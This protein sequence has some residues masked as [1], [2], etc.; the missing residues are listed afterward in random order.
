MNLRRDIFS[1]LETWKDTPTRKPLIIH[2]A[3]Q[4]GKTWTMRHFG[5]T[6]YRNVAYFNFEASPEL[7]AE[8]E[9]TKDVKRLLTTLS[10]FHGAPIEPKETLIIFDEIQE[11]NAAL[12][13]LKYFCE[14]APEYHVM[15]AGSLLG[16]ALASGDGFPVGKT[17]FLQMYPVTFK[18]FL[19]AADKT[20]H[21]FIDGITSLEPLPE[22]ALARLEEHFRRYQVCGGMPAAMA[23]MLSGKNIEEIEQILKSILTAYALDFS[24]HAP[25]REIPRITAVWDSIPSQ[26]AR[27]NRKFL[28]KNVKPGA[29]AREYEDALLWLK[30]AGL[31]HQVFCASRPGLPISA[32]DDLSAFK[33][34]MFD[35]ALL[36][37]KAGLS[38]EVLLSDNPLFR[39]FKGAM[40]ENQI[41]QSLVTQ[42]DTLPRY[43]VSS[44]TAEVDFLLQ[45]ATDVIPIEVKA[46]TNTSGKSLKVY[47]DK[48][49]PAKAVIYSRNNL[50]KEPTLLHIPIYIADWTARWLTL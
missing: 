22:F 30:Q 34:Y 7:S 6:H 38:H 43:W 32:Y 16:V 2:G 1:R 8:F 44:G 9:K 46:A 20:L 50:K 4:I 28:Y 31:T 17:D 24:K 41:L 39:E 21:D 37:V 12:N 5:E 3:R 48:F 14:D 35:T 36:R 45:T 27:E 47:C 13:S 19:N 40:A 11:C 29:R 15:A 26:L 10:L 25:G 18:E 33:I 23:N 42:F 49:S